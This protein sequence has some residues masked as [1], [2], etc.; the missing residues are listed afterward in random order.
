M[1]KKSQFEIQIGRGPLGPDPWGGHILISGG[2]P[3]LVQR[4]R[5]E[6]VPSLGC[7]T[8]PDW[9]GLTDLADLSWWFSIAWVGQ[10]GTKLL[11]TWFQ[12]GT[13][14]SQKSTPRCIPSWTLF[15]E[16]FL[17][18][19][20]SQLRPPESQKSSPRCSESTIF[21][22]IALRNWHR[23]L[24]DFGANLAP[25]CLPKSSKILPKIDPKMHQIFD[26]FLHRFFVHFSSNLGPKLGPCWPLF[27]LKREDPNSGLHFERKSGQHGPKLGPKLEPKWRKNRCKNRS[28]IWCI[29][30]SIFGRILVDFGRENGAKLA[31]K[32]IENLYQLRKIFFWKIAF[33][34][35]HRFFVDV[36]ANM[37][38][39]SP[40][41]S[42]KIL[43]KIDP[44]MHQFF[45]RF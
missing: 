44:K 9:L 1:A 39:F 10:H 34:K 27:R 30:G 45:D 6:M 23:F 11:P 43:P 12:N 25:F 18:H 16:R 3:T 31:P 28:K 24:I 14:I 29:L 42:T 33:R 17:I 36:G 8:W 41:K 19:F 37:L 35:L 13:K 7:L 40:Q 26:R 21:Q 20:C 38:P 5:G 32:S 4:D 22:K 2:N 15:F